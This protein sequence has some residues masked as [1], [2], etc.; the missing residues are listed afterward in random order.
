MKVTEVMSNEIELVKTDTPLMEAAK[1]MSQSEVGVLPVISGHNQLVGMLTDRDIAIRSVA[2][3]HDPKTTPVK[4]A[5][6]DK[7]VSCF[8]D[9]TVDEVAK[10]MQ[11]RKLRRMIVVD[12]SNGAVTGIVSIGDIAKVS[13]DKGIAGQTLARVCEE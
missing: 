13:D 12:R 3:G 7:V 6:T 4:A 1:T 8:T 10:S 2:H 9:Q 5:M 11:E